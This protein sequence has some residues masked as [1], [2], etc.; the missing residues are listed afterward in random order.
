MLTTRLL[1]LI[2]KLKQ[3]NSLSTVTAFNHLSNSPLKKRKENLYRFLMFTSKEQILALKSVCIGKPLSS[4]S[5]YFGRP[6]VLS[7][8]KKSNIYTEL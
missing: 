7:N 2:T 3:M 1:F 5:V 6:L 4:A 8:I